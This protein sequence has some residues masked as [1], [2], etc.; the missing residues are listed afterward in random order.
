M[1][2]EVGCI[3]VTFFKNLAFDEFKERFMNVF[4][5]GATQTVRPVRLEP[6]QYFRFTLR[7][8]FLKCPKN[9]I[10]INPKKCTPLE[11]HQYFKACVATGNQRSFCP[12][13]YINFLVDESII[14]NF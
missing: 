2:L 5:S 9:A 12:L 11:P 10:K 14:K 4:W 7:G 6:P 3:L 8:H 1:F 13:F